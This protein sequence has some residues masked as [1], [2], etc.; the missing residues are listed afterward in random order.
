MRKVRTRKQMAILGNSGKIQ[1]T[2]RAMCF[3]YRGSGGSRNRDSATNHR[4]EGG[5]LMA[6]PWR[7]VEM[8]INIFGELG[9]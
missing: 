7:V 8:A 4:I 6:Q 3:T 1:K 2:Q 9:G 5:R